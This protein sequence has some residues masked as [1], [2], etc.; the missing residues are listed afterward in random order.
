M[1]TPPMVRISR[2]VSASPEAPVAALVTRR[3]ISG[4]TSS[5]TVVMAAHS[6]SITMV[7]Q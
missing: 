2:A 6:R 1:Y 5:H 7:P 3:T 4:S